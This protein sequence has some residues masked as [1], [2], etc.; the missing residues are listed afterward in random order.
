MHGVNGDS[1]GV[2]EEKSLTKDDRDHAEMARA[3]VGWL[4]GV[5][6]ADGPVELKAV[7]EPSGSGLSSVTLVI[8]CAW[9]KD[10]TPHERRLAVRAAPHASAYPVFPSYDLPLQHD[11]MAAVAAGTS[12]PVP[13]L[14]GLEETGSVLG[15]PF[16]VMEAVEGRAPLDNPPYVF[17]GWL[18]DATPE[19]RAA[20]EEGTLGVIAG[21]HGLNEPRL[22][23]PRLAAL[24]GEDALRSHVESQRAYYGWTQEQDGLRVPLIERAF[25]WL[26]EHWPEDPGDPVLCWGDARPGNILFDGVTPVAVLDWEMT[27]IAPREL[28][29]GWYVFI[30]RFFQ[31]IA[32]VFELPG[33]PDLAD[34]DRVAATY[35]RLSGHAPRDLHWYVVYAALRHGIV[36]ARI[37]RRMIHFGEEVAPDDPDDYVMHRAALEELIGGAA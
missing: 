8:D 11:V 13:P 20:V 6:D 22:A 5:L 30:H 10:G 15:S 23:V 4:Q 31:D 18:H 29:V 25:D 19:E 1:S 32:A 24:A 14:V 17:G 3:V 7:A 21:V 9:V 33:L 27:T 16:L 36:M 28:D 2:L 35:E 37:K 26:E 12:V 34:V